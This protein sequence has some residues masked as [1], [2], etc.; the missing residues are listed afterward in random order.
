MEDFPTRTIT[1]TIDSSSGTIVLNLDL[2]YLTVMNDPAIG[3]PG[4]EVFLDG[5]R[6]GSIPLIRKKVSAGKHELVVRWPDA[7]EPFR[8][9]V[10]MPQAPAVLQLTVAPGGN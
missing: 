7:K 4:G 9:D 10:E 2:G 8:Q 5:D 3:L 1:R 6:I